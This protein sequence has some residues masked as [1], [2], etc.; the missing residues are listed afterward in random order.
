M[1]GHTRGP[2]ELSGDD[3]TNELDSGGEVGPE[4]PE[5]GGSGMRKSGGGGD[6]QAWGD[7]LRGEGG[8]PPQVWMAPRDWASRATHANANVSGQGRPAGRRP[9]ERIPADR[10]SAE[11][12]PVDGREIE[13]RQPE[14]R[15]VEGRQVG[16]RPVDGR[17]IEE[18]PVQT[19]PVETRQ[20]GEADGGVQGLG[21]LNAFDDEVEG[22]N[23][24]NRQ[25]AER[26]QARGRRRE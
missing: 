22:R 1:Y 11:R 12:R 21:V 13:G 2:S 8:T 24:V 17:E 5:L 16:R 7:G 18:R 20:E 14:R 26:R 4:S 15:P 9:A 10:R 25:R 23:R 19:R 6:G 3:I